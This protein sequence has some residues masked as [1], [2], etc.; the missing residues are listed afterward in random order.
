MVA[1]VV[2]VVVVVTKPTIFHGDSDAFRIYFL[3]TGEE[4]KG[5]FRKSK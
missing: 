5:G 4:V 2:V 3:G 1:E